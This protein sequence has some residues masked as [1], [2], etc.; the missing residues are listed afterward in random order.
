VRLATLRL[1][2]GTRAARVEGDHAVLL[3]AADVGAV[4]ADP[5]WPTAAAAAGEA[6]GLDG[7]TYAPLVPRPSKIV[8]VGLNYR[9]HIEEMGRSLPSAP[10]LFAKFAEC[11]IGARDPLALPSVSEQVDWEVELAVVVGRPLRRATPREARDAIAGY[12]V[13]NDVSMR[14]WQNRTLQWLSG[15]TFE[16]TTP[17]GPWLTTPDEVDHADDLEVRCEVDG[18]VMQVSRTSDLVFP[19]A[20]LLAYISQ[21]ITLQPG[22]LL[23]TGTPGG[24]GSARDP[25]VFLRPGQTLRTAIE[26]LGECVNLCVKE[27]PA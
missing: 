20:E 10:T 24:V 7:V 1:D 6:V 15:K 26:G 9:S 17:V 23:A 18:E 14:D 22:D 8:C 27:E 21:I 12:S 19:P 25:K 2:N 3:A 13:L 5:D 16:A 11:L 4:L